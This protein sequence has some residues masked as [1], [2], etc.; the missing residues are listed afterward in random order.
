MGNTDTS[1]TG[2]LLAHGADVGGSPIGGVA[3][4]SLVP[5]T[6]GNELEYGLHC[7][8]HCLILSQ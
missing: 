8:C 2:E 1:R 5:A 6:V 4:Q 3:F 7:A